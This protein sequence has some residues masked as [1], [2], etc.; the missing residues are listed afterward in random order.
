ML[1]ANRLLLEG[2]ESK[3]DGEID[4][5]SKIKGPVVVAKRTQITNSKLFGPLIIGSDS[6]IK[7][8]I[9][10]P[11]VSIDDEVEIGKSKISSSIVMGGAKIKCLKEMCESL[12]GKHT[13]IKLDK[14]SSN[15]NSGYRFI[16][17]DNSRILTND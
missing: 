12:I 2:L 17:G 6:L 8:S 10:G 4:S 11:C 5:S 7:D 1:E 15:L 14:G 16:L 13:Q 3:I 9:L